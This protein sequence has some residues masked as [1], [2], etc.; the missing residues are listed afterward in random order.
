MISRHVDIW[1]VL[2]LLFGFA[3]F[4]RTNDTVVRIAKAKMNVYQ[5]L[6]STGV[7]ISPF[8]LNRFGREPSQHTPAAFRLI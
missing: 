8:R 7:R 2:L 6:R 5:G 1:A 4:T 3:L